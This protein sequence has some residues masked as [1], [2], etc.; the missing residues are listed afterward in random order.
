ML[1]GNKKKNFIK[2]SLAFSRMSTELAYY[3]FPVL[4]PEKIIEL[5]FLGISAIEGSQ[6][7]FSNKD[8][9]LKGNQCTDEI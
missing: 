4:N 1:G 7:I 8:N 3:S 2:H 5:S 6:I 9:S